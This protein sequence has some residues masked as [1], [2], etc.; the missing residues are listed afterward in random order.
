MCLRALKFMVVTAVYYVVLWQSV[1]YFARQTN[2]FNVVILY[3]L[4][5]IS[6]LHVL[7]KA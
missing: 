7:R 4:K 6:G 5:I 1:I 2:Q 3:W